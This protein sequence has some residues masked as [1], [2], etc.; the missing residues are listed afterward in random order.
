LR[1]TDEPQIVGVARR[2][3]GERIETSHATPLDT[4]RRG[5]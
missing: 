5:L 1:L 2:D 4:A 3:F